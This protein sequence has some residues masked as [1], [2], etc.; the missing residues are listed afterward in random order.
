LFIIKKFTVTT[1]DGGYKATCSVEVLQ[2]EVTVP[3]STQTKPGGKE[4]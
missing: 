2:Q 1:E 4:K 3:D